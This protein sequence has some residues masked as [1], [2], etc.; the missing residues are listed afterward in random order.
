MH[1]C[2]PPSERINPFPT[3]RAAEK[4]LFALVRGA[5]SQRRKTLQNTLSSSLG[6]GKP[7]IAGALE[8]IGVKTTARAEELSLE[9]LIALS[10]TLG[11]E[12]IP[13]QKEK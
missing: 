9:Q 8:Q 2:I 11:E 6:L 10:Q 4:R 3:N 7:V 12:M 1:L 5:F 13:V